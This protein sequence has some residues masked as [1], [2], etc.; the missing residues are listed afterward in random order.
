MSEVKFN[1]KD[2][3]MIEDMAQKEWREINGEHVLARAYVHAVSVWLK[4][5]NLLK[6]TPTYQPRNLS[7][8]SC[9][10]D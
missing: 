9:L 10:E 6:E 8:N 4:N 5:K 3:S 1:D 7:I 2:L